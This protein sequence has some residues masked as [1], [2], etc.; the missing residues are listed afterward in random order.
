[1]LV[2]CPR[3]SLLSKAVSHSR[4]RLTRQPFVAHGLVLGKWTKDLWAVGQS[5]YLQ[6]HVFFPPPPALALL[7]A[8][9]SS[10]R[11]S[12]LTRA[13]DKA[14]SPNSRGKEPSLPLVA[15]SGNFPLFRPDSWRRKNLECIQSRPVPRGTSRA[16]R[17]LCTHLENTVF[18]CM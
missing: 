17:V 8:C 7:L 15:R 6:S 14:V 5:P 9:V 13:S 1:M 11:P 12:I 16:H 2:V 10:R 3:V 18:S 4:G